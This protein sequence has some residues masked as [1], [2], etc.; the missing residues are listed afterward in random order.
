MSGFDR[1]VHDDWD[2]V[3][4]FDADLTFEPDY[5]ERCLARFEADDRLGIGG[6]KILDPSP[7]RHK[8]DKPEVVQ[9]LEILRTGEPAQKLGAHLK[10]R[11]G[12]GLIPADTQAM[13]GT[14]LEQAR[15]LLGV[16][17]KKELA[18]VAYT[19]TRRHIDRGFIEKLETIALKVLDTYHAQNPLQK[20]L[21]LA[22]L[23]TRFPRHI[24]P[25]LVDFA[26]ERMSEGGTVKIEG[27]TIRSASFTV[28]LST[29]DTALRSKVTDAIAARG[30]EAPT[31]EEAA[32][33]VGEE[34]SALKPVLDYLVD[35]A[36]LVRTKEGLYFDADRIGVLVKEVKTLLASQ[37]Q[38]T[39]AEVK[40]YTGVSRKYLIPLMEYLDNR[41]I[42]RRN[43]DV[44]ITGPKG[45]K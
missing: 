33:L 32:V 41:Q 42:T 45:R 29:Q 3:V 1:I 38:I 37:G 17:V 9:T 5:F 43:G 14:T 2:Y 25:K 34:A 8:G 21:G 10:L 7:V 19:K 20:G 22:E 27:D 39:V 28:T 4:K 16:A 24:D 31:L 15:N 12:R 30:F 23:R 13:L 11:S 6:G 35:E 40:G 36:C 44:R 26:L 18:L